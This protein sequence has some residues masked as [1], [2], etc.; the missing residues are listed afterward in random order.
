MHIR[1]QQT[2]PF[3][4]QQ[5]H[6]STVKCN[7][8]F[9][10]PLHPPSSPAVIPCDKSII[11]KTPKNISDNMADRELLPN[12]NFFEI[13]P[14]FYKFIIEIP[15]KFPYYLSQL[16]LISLFQTFSFS[17]ELK[18]ENLKLSGTIY[19]STSPSAK[20]FSLIDK[21]KSNFLL[22]SFEFLNQLTSTVLMGISK[23][24]FMNTKSSNTNGKSI[25]LFAINDNGNDCEASW[26]TF[27]VLIS[28]GKDI[29]DLRVIF[30][31]DSKPG[32]FEDIRLELAKKFISQVNQYLQSGFFYYDSKKKHVSYKISQRALFPVQENFKLPQKMTSEAVHDYTAYAYGLFAIYNMEK[33]I[34]KGDIRNIILKLV[35]KCRKRSCKPFYKFT[36]V[37]EKGMIVKRFKDIQGEE[38]CTVENKII[39]LLQ[40]NQLLREVFMLD[41]IKNSCDNLMY[42]IISSKS[43][44][45]LTNL[46]D[47]SPEIYETLLQLLE[48]LCEVGLQIS[49]KALTSAFFVYQN[50]I[51]FNFAVLFQ[52]TL[53]NLPLAQSDAYLEILHNYILTCISLEG[54]K[55]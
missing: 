11:E 27:P 9:K 49:E 3:K 1:L 31:I 29:I 12:E 43:A 52:N 25:Y 37:R 36:L 13:F 14:N 51:F 24:G 30:A 23:M 16:D 35:E 50:R 32:I 2:A 46:N 18:K 4:P 8:P 34:D 7:G 6:P 38:I 41:K 42:P 19:S 22:T 26:A 47:M 45:N 55:C 39:S 15:I 21:I 10:F 53:Q 17:W 40:K 48:N 54:P 44:T 5:P 20:L 33:L 28:V